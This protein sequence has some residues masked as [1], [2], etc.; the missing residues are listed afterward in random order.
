MTVHLEFESFA[1]SKRYKT[2]KAKIYDVML[3]E[4]FANSKRYK[5]MPGMRGVAAIV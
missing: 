3:F 1:N 5:T 2:V 4:S